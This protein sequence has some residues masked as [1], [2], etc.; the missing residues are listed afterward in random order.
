MTI[1]NVFGRYYKGDG[2]KFVPFSFSA[3]VEE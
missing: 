2:I 3:K 1:R